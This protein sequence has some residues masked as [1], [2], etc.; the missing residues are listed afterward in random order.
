[1]LSRAP[2]PAS[3]VER[4]VPHSSRWFVKATAHPAL[5]PQEVAG[6]SRQSRAIQ[7]TPG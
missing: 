4:R 3:R 7:A 5:I 1:M 2:T 6:S